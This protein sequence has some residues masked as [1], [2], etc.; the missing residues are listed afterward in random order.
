[1]VV[2]SFFLTMFGVFGARAGAIGSLAL[3]VMLLN[4]LSL[5]ESFSTL[6]AAALIFA[7]GLWYMVFS[8][9]LH[10]IRP[11]RAVE[12]VLGEHI[13]AIADYVRARAGFYREESDLTESFHRVMKAQSEVQDI[14]EQAQEMLFKTRRLVADASP[15]SRSLM[16]I[17][18]ES[19]DLF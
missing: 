8:M 9:L 15:R 2:L 10:G 16:M 17:Y 4:L 1:I 14:Q 5:N 7:G 18:L 13:I 11:Y 12:Q 3:V 19:L 6:Q